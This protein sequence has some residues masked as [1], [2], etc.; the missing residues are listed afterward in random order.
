M[1]WAFDGRMKGD[2]KGFPLFQKKKKE[3][4][5]EKGTKRKSHSL[6]AETLHIMSLTIPPLLG[7]R[8]EAEDGN[9]GGNGY[10]CGKGSVP[11]LPS[12]KMVG[13]GCRVHLIFF[14]GGGGAERWDPWF[15]GEYCLRLLWNGLMCIGRDREREREEPTC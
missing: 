1:T 3:K 14:V 6:G 11:D 15:C 5:K 2:R 4:E 10:G 8:L 7:L 9:E 12:V 13:S